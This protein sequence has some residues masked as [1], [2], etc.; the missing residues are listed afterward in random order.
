[1]LAT[2]LVLAIAALAACAEGPAGRLAA[3]DPIGVPVC[4][5]WLAKYNRCIDDRMPEDARAPMRR[6]LLEAIHT[7][8]HTAASSAGRLALEE[9]CARRIER[10]RRATESMGCAW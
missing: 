7:W 3:G 8:R 9:T 4:D 6:A 5:E 2:G 1:M 10:T